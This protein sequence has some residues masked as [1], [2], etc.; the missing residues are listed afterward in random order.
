MDKN[1]EEF[2]W[3][4]ASRE[5][6]IEPTKALY[7]ALRTASDVTGQSIDAMI[8]EALG[9]N[10]ELGTDYISN[11][12]RGNIAAGRA[13]LIHRWL[14]RHHFDI[15]QDASP[16]LFQIDPVSA[17]DQFINDQAEPDKLTVI[18]LRDDMGIVQ[19]A[20][21]ISDQ[22][23]TL[24]L[25]QNFYLELDCPCDGMLVAFQGYAGQWHPLPLAEDKRRLRIPVTTGT[26]PL[27][28]NAKGEPIPIVEVDDAGVHRFIAVLSENRDLPTVSTDIMGHHKEHPVKVFDVRVAVVG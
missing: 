6:R 12:R 28:R 20:A 5:D 15:A 21:D 3:T 9:Q 25:G 24:R 11:F 23:P 22:M 1:I 18:P 16:D 2:D 8:I 19:R 14:E 26:Q 7:K 27:P 13:M 17:W 10:I 4:T